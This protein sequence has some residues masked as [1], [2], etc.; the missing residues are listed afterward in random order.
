MNTE[1]RL[2]CVVVRI[3]RVDVGIDADIKYNYYIDV[4][5]HY[6]NTDD[7]HSRYAHLFSPVHV[8]TTF[9]RLSVGLRAW[10]SVPDFVQDPIISA[11]C[12][13][14]LFKTYLFARY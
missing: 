13:R 4:H 3:Y 12:F 11:D 10:N 1:P 7:D 6:D 5:I 9:V 14:R 8:I 2:Y